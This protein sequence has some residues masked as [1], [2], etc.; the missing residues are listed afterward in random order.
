MSTTEQQIDVVEYIQ[1]KHKLFKKN[2]P[3]DIEDF[4]K[5]IILL[6]VDDLDDTKHVWCEKWK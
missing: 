5:D 1:L 2:L 3:E 4:T 6:I